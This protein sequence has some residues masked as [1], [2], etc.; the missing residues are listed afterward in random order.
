[1]T[2]GVRHAAGQETM[3]LRGSQPQPVQIFGTTNTGIKVQLGAATMVEPFANVVAVTMPAPP[4]F[5]AAETAYEHN[6][7]P[8]ALRNATSVVSN[9]R[10]LPTDWAREAM[11]MLGDIDVSM[12]QLPQARAAYQD[13]QRMYPTA[14]SA[15]LNVGLARIDV[16]NKDYTAAK[17]KIDPIL[18]DALKKRNL[19]TQTAALIGRAFF[20][21]G[22][23]KQA[24]G[25]LQG[26]LVDYLRTVTIF[27]QDRVAVVNAEQ[28]ADALRKEHDGLAVP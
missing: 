5:T 8:S 27:P 23:I 16:A 12:G 18:A 11:L 22:E 17:A 21:S 1:M 19:P 3:T 2:L 20:V 24:T 9:F 7:L 10:G 13:Y 25:D 26:A 14:G 4:E 15:D 6:D 28:H